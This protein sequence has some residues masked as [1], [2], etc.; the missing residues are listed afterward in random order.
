[1]TLVQALGLML[2]AIAD[3]AARNGLHWAELLFWIG[4]VVIFGPAAARLAAGEP[5]RQERIAL[6][7]ALVVALYIVKVLR[8]PLLFVDHDEFF[9][10]RTTIDIL[11][12]G[13]LFHENPLLPVSSLYPGME[14]ATDALVKLSGLTIFQAGLIVIGV[15]RLVVV[16][17]LF[18]FVEQ[19]VRS[20]RIAGIACLVYMGEP[21]FLFFNGL[22]KYESLALAYAM[23][24]LFAL[25]RRDAAH[26][27]G[28]I[29]FTVAA[30][31][32]LAATVI[33]HHITAYVLTVFLALWLVA[34]WLVGRGRPHRWGPGWI[35]LLAAALNV[36]WLSDIA[37]PTVEYLSGPINNA[38]LGVVHLISHEQQGGGGARQLFTSNTGQVSPLWERVTTLTGVA[39]IMLGLPFG[40]FQVWRRHRRTAVAVVLAVAALGYP[41]ALGLRFVGAAWEVGNRTSEFI[42]VALGFVLALAAVELWLARH[43][44]WTWSLGLGICAS[45]IFVSGVIAGWP[46]GWRLPGPYA[47]LQAPLS[48]EPQ[49][50]TMSAWM[51]Q[52]VGANQ[53]VA[54]DDFN[55]L[56]L[57]GYGDQW[58]SITLNGGIDANWILYAPF[59]G[60]DQLELLRQGGVRY[61]VVD[62]RIALAPD[63]NRDYYPGV[64]IAGA[65]AKYRRVK[66]ISRIYDSGDIAIYDVRS[67]SGAR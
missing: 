31:L 29:G 42:F 12:T 49:G 7:I 32:G 55:D 35:L 46:P 36:V 16:L 48:V 30:V 52:H 19:I 15:A 62:R 20:P 45:I 6:V 57:E 41:A 54:T 33:T 4:L 3:T 25:V 66:T 47:A 26:D 39:L 13:H 65:L 5:R 9:H 58:V 44:S 27:A 40:L 56:L 8:S 64:S 17:A 18:L 50:L 60:P 21:N 28:R 23:L 14:V 59:F 24:V 67:L 43:S 37:R 11:R 2:V 1:L 53:K 22:F 61:L 63:S 10:V 51:S 38:I 34:A